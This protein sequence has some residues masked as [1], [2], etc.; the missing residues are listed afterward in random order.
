MSDPLLR[1]LVDLRDQQIQKAR[2][3]F[4]NRIGAIER[5]DDAGTPEQL[6]VL[7]R[8]F[9]RFQDLEARLE[10]DIADLVEQYPIYDHVSAV[11]GIGPMLAAKLIAMIDVSRAPTVSSLWRYA[12]Y[13]LSKYWQNEAGNIVA[14]VTGYE[15]DSNAKDWKQVSPEPKDGW[16]CVT[17]PDRL[18]KGYRSPYNKRLKTA[19]Y[20]IAGSMMKAGSPY[21]EIYDSAKARYVANR[22]WTKGHCDAAARRKMIKIFLSHLWERW[23]QLEGLEIRATYVEEHL[24]HDNISRPEDY[25]WPV[26]EPGERKAA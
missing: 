6:A 15:W 19:L 3:Q 11:K 22:D 24:G 8:Y 21:R 12:G 20:V 18:I 17:V 4:Q 1:A 14:P 25:G 9:E 7:K 26:L 2:K 16:T 5:N 23:R 10:E 13:G